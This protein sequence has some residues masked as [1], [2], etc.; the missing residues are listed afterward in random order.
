MGAASMAGSSGIKYSF[1][2]KKITITGV[3]K[4]TGTWTGI[5]VYTKSALNVIDNAKIQYAGGKAVLGGVKA[6]VAL[7]GTSATSLVVQNSEIS[8]SGGFGIHVYGDKAMLNGNVE[9]VNTFINNLQG[10]IFYDL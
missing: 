5:V 9:T 3:V 2:T 8:N 6:S 7:F 1:P 4:A 10:N